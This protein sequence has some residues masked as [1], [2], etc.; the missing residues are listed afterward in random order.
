MDLRP[1]AYWDCGFESRREHVCLSLVTVVCCQVEVSDT[2]WSLVQRSLTDCDGSFCDIYKPKEWGGHDS[3]WTAAKKKSRRMK[4]AHWASEE[5]H[6]GSK[7]VAC[8]QKNHTS[9]RPGGLKPCDLAPML[10]RN[11]KPSP[12]STAHKLSVDTTSLLLNTYTVLLRAFLALL[13]KL[14]KGMRQYVRIKRTAMWS[15]ASRV[16]QCGRPNQAYCNV[17]VRIKRTA[18]WSSTI[19]KTRYKAIIPFPSDSTIEVI[20]DFTHT[21]QRRSY[22]FVQ[23]T[24]KYLCSH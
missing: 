12:T 22:G 8:A 1:L 13:S 6:P 5:W 18:M 21:H 19:P 16:L 23:T 17:V 4:Y 20:S 11:S 3:S 14:H 7:T 15:S 2:S 9:H 10:Q 24:V